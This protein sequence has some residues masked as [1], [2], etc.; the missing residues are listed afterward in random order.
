MHGRIGKLEGEVAAVKATQGDVEVS[1]N[2]FKD[3]VGSGISDMQ[4]KAS[5]SHTL[6]PKPVQ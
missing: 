6:A 4:N 5:A 2:N 1:F 3:V